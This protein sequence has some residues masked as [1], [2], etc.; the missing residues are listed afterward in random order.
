MLLGSEFEKVLFPQVSFAQGT[1]W[2][3]YKESGCLAERGGDFFSPPPLPKK[4]VPS[5]FHSEAS[6]VFFPWLLFLVRHFRPV[7]NVELFMGMRFKCSPPL[8][9][10]SRQR[11]KERHV[12]SCNLL[13]QFH[14]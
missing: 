8:L 7:F 10:P 1:A 4:G 3:R 12:L 6:F 11:D 9:M 14:H 2:R 13:H 5:W